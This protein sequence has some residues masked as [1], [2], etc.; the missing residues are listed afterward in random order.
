M[1]FIS[2]LLVCFL[3]FSCGND[4]KDSVQQ[5]ENTAGS[6]PIEQLPKDEKSA[7]E[8]SDETTTVYDTIRANA[9]GIIDWIT[10]KKKIRKGQTLYSFEN[11]A[12]FHQLGTKKELLRN[13]MDSLVEAANGDLTIVKG[14]WKTFQS[15]LRSDT[16][17]PNFPKIQYREE[18]IHF[19]NE[20]ITRTY[21][22]IA[23]LEHKMKSNFVLAKA[24]YSTLVWKIK[25]GTQVK[26][27]KIIAVGKRSDLFTV[28]I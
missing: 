17:L 6:R 18:G 26:K 2:T 27:G 13:R 1:K 10:P 28:N 15:S 5:T 23:Q 8:Y 16:L 22:E 3:L 9:S 24:S 12:A 19:G 20:S 4:E 21:N 14:K 11:S 25:S 7:E